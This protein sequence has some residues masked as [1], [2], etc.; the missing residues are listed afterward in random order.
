MVLG[1]LG[2]RA[3]LIA[4]AGCGLRGVSCAGGGARKDGMAK[5]GGR[6]VALACCWVGVLLW[7]GGLR[8]FEAVMC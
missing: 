4:S 2:R 3:R 5:G 6:G 8:G 1:L 7:R